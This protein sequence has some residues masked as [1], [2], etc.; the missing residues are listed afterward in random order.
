MKTEA[1]IDFRNPRLVRKL[2]MDALTK[3]LG[4]VGMAYFMRQFD[5]GSGDYTAERDELLAGVTIDDVL[6][7]IRKLKEEVG[8]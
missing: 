6:A 4:A 7:D 8:G 1:T 2:G 5:M 3:E